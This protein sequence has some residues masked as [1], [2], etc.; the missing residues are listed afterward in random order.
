MSANISFYNTNATQLT[1]LYGSLEFENVHKSWCLYWPNTYSKVLDIGAGSGRDAQWF[2]QKGCSVVAVEPAKEL[3]RLGSLSTPPQI[4]WLDDSL[5]TLLEVRKLS[6]EYDLI[7]ISAV[8]MHLNA[9]QREE[10]IAVLS[11][12]LSESGK[13]VIT[14][15]HGSFDDDRDAFCV[16]IDELKQLGQ[17]VGL[18]VCHIVDDSDSLN[19]AEIFWQTVVLEKI[20]NHLARE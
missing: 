5:P 2:L 14:L 7:L 17:V 11:S 13:L 16:S 18:T 15:R 12:L 20:N 9:M 4:H 19:R 1:K 6:C 8:W 10:S 3:R